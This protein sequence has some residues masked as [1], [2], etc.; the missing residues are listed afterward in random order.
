MPTD[1]EILQAQLR[2]LNSRLADAKREDR[3]AA[4]N[5]IRDQVA[6]Y[7]ISEEE[8]LSAAGFRKPPKRRAAAKYYD[9]SSGKAWSGEVASLVRTVF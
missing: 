6:L 1:L 2:E 9:P 3:R 8:L 7:S 5:A 4:L